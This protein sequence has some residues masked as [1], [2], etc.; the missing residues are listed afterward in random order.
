MDRVLMD[1]ADIYVDTPRTV[2]TTDCV[3]F[4]TLDFFL[5]PT[6]FVLLGAQ[7][8]YRIRRKSPTIRKESKD[9]FRRVAAF[10]FA[11]FFLYKED[12]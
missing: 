1:L 6:L 5:L 7:N 10:V 9:D 8:A 12:C 3:L 4:V 11:T 2:S